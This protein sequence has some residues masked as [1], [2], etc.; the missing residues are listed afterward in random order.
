MLRYKYPSD[1]QSFVKH[2]LFVM[3][4][5]SLLVS[6]H[7]RVGP[8]SLTIVDP[9]RHYYPLVQGEDLRMTYMIINSGRYPFI[10]QDIQP[11][12]L[13]IEFGKEPPHL[14]PVG[15]SLS[16]SLIFHTD[17]NIG[18]VEH[19]V[20]IFGNVNVVNDSSMIG[21]AVLTFDT[22]IVRPSL[23]QS[24]YEER[25]WEKKSKSEKLV[26]GNRGEQGYYTDE[27]V[28]EN[29]LN[30]NYEFYPNHS[31]DKQVQRTVNILNGQF[32]Q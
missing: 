5:C 27:D 24:D 12:S 17:R 29:Q 7:K 8:T 26:D 2:S 11:A 9:I 30:D 21:E 16:L 18:Y 20:R 4:L 31:R 6:C 32:N 19:K 22:H 13:S 1:M 25:Y 28:L 3:L 23:D 10:V 15:D 14:I